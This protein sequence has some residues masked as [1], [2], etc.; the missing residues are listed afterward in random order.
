[1][2]ILLLDAI[3]DKELLTMWLKEKIDNVLEKEMNLIEENE[4]FY[5]GIVVAWKGNEI[6]LSIPDPEEGS[7]T[8]R[9]RIVVS[10]EDVS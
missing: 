3:A 8:I 4:P 1:M 6:G 10:N 7:A 2:M 5:Y 9:Y